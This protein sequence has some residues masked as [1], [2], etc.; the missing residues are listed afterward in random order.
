MYLHYS[1]EF[2][3]LTEKL[4][5]LAEDGNLEGASFTYMHIVGTC[6]SCH[7]YS[8]DVLRIADL[9]KKPKSPLRLLGKDAT[10]KSIS[11]HA[12]VSD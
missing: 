5:R 8:R 4:D 10:D 2:S 11:A 12:L 3:R 1:R 6:L 9:N 7:E